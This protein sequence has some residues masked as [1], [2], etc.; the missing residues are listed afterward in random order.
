MNTLQKRSIV[1]LFISVFSLCLLIS[2]MGCGAEGDNPEK[3]TDPG[4]ARQH[5]GELSTRSLFESSD[6]EV[7]FTVSSDWGSGYVGD[8]TITNRSS[9]RINDW[10]LEFD[11][12]NEITGIWS[13]KI[14]SDES[15]HYVLQGE[16]WNSFIEPGKSVSFG[17][18][19]S[20]G[21]VTVGPGGYKL[22]GEGAGHPGG[23]EVTS[24]KITVKYSTESDWGSGFTGNIILKNEGDAEVSDWKLDF[25]FNHRITSIWNAKIDSHTENHYSIEP[26]SYNKTIPAGGQ[27]S[28]GFVGS[29]GNVTEGPVNIRVDASGGIG[30]TPEPS[31][32][33]STEPSPEPTPEPS[34]A[35][36]PVPTPT[37]TP[38]PTPPTGGKRV[39]AYFVNWGIYARNYLVTDIPA[40]KITHI[41]Y[42]FFAIDSSNN[43]VKM[44][45][46]WADIEKVFTGAT[47]KGFPDQTWDESARGEAGC[48]GRL[49]QLKAIHPHI[50]TLMSI[51]GWTLS[52][53][54]PDV[55]RTEASRQQFVSSCVEMMVKYD[56]DGIDIDWEYPGP[57][58]KTNC[59]LLMKEFRRQLDLQGAKDNKHY[60]LTMAGPAGYNKLLNLEIDKLAECLD[61]L[62]IMTYDF[63]GGWD[64][65]TNHHSPLYQNPDDPI[66]S[67]DRE[68]LNTDWV[69]NYYINAGM[70]AD[71]LGMGVPFYGR[72]WEEV[73]DI[74]NGLFQSG[75]SLPATN[76]PGNW[77]AGMFDY[78]KIQD[79]LANSSD[80]TRFWDNSAKVPWVYGKN[81][82]PQKTSGGMFITYEDTESL[83]GKC[84]YLKDKG[85]GGIMFWELSGDIKDSNDSRS[86]LNVIYREIVNEGR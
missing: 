1:I 18:Q 23:G 8:M 43:S 62:N 12:D 84:Q 33:P 26:E 24:G 46:R 51:G 52:Y 59:T 79:I 82:S 48:L 3:L 63:H 37:P 55:A 17:F 6:F 45:D 85:L 61:F 67:I 11:F 60:L 58:D 70:P 15:G 42:A 32:E 68:M 31:P 5:S 13:A 29:P 14:I 74:N 83:A 81:L 10:Q 76:Q 57:A 72:A 30:P 77:E 71:K 50:K 35:P 7:K 19:G 44:I 41:N 20:P 54:F 69:I 9:E 73:P 49:K 78:W 28:F 2:M 38:T 66:N 36:S 39:V 21:G 53:N 80:Y 56:F 40:E 47:D 75:P 86:L 16:S 64:N 34:P 25:D 65:T 4:V 22:T 27:I